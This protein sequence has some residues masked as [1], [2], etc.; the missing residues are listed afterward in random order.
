[1]KKAIVLAILTA[2]ILVTL[3]VKAPDRTQSKP[4]NPQTTPSLTIENS[5]LSITAEECKSDLAY[6]ASDE[7]EGRM[8]GKKGNV[9]AA[10]FIKDRLDRAGLRTLTQRF[11]IK[12]INP[13]PKQEVGD[14]F[15]ENVYA[16][17]EGSE[18]PDEIVV[19]GAHFDHIGYGPK[20]SRG[21]GLEVHNGADDN[22]SG[23]VAV[24]EAATAL[25]GLKPKRTILFQFY[26]AEEMGLLGSRHYCENPMF[27]ESNPDISKHIAMI[28][29][30][31]VGHLRTSEYK[32]SVPESAPDIGKII[33][34]LTTRYGFARNVTGRGTGGSDHASFYN[35]RIPVAFIH[36]GLH[37]H[38]H[39][40]SDD[41]ETLNI[42]GIAQ[43]ARYA[44]E[45][46]WMLADEANVPEF[47]ESK[48]EEMPYL[49][50]HGIGRF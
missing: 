43:I 9:L 17:I 26:S 21:G 25:A 8:S 45:L 47:D 33:D 31:M 49:H 27:P 4:T 48:F 20:Y 18:I 3:T 30:D 14:E 19:M 38:Y 15:T 23:T 35:K 50:D 2:A 22:A 36:T 46:V 32:V 39:T 11:K 28:N 6:L 42:D 16:V 12:S 41:L 44:A 1:M 29:L 37:R 10:K 40:P 7:L 5:V 13:G 24:L 34:E